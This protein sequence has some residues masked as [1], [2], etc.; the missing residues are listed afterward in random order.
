[1]LRPSTRKGKRF[2]ITLN[3]K[4]YH[5]GSATGQTFIDHA[6]ELKKQNYLKR[7]QVRED[8]TTVN[9]GSLSRFILW[10]PSPDI[11][12]NLKAFLEHIK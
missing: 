2:M 12:V 8:W 10:G 11:E 6:D 4:T 7:H 9:P 1:M 5:F 3:G